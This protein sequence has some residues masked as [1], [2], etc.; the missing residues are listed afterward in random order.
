MFA[1]QSQ[2]LTDFGKVLLLI[3]NFLVF[4]DAAMAASARESYSWT[5]VPMGG[6][7]FKEAA[8]FHETLVAVARRGHPALRLPPS[9][10]VLKSGAFVS[11]RPRIEDDEIHARKRRRT[12]DAPRPDSGARDREPAGAAEECEDERVGR[13]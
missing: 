7:G 2:R 11:L 10:Q 3:T 4:C 6:G 1:S 13:Q 8:L 5:N 12:E 9:K